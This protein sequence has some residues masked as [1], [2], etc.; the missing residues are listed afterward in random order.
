[1]I[2]ISPCIVCEPMVFS[3]KWIKMGICIHLHVCHSCSEEWPQY[4]PPADTNIT[5]IVPKSTYEKNGFLPKA[6][7]I[8]VLSNGTSQKIYVLAFCCCCCWLPPLLFPPSAIKLELILNQTHKEFK[9]SYKQ[10]LGKRQSTSVWSPCLKSKG[11]G[12]RQKYSSIS[13]L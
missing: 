6:Y 1:M 11:W 9:L 4:S 12:L 10:M 2:W 3:L 7:C 13:H 5:L 8:T